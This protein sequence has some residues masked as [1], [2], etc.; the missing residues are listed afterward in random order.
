M[1]YDYYNEEDERAYRYYLMDGGEP[2]TMLDESEWPDF[3][4]EDDEL[5]GFY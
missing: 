1:P 5:E 3:D 4:F 2:L